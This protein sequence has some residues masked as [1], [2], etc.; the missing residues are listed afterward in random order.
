MALTVKAGVESFGTADVAAALW[1]RK[2]KVRQ[3]TVS[4]AVHLNDC[5][6]FIW[7]GLVFLVLWSSIARLKAGRKGQQCNVSFHGAMMTLVGFSGFR[8]SCH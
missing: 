5:V 6:G 4:S 1:V 7:D 2:L 3:I 8:T